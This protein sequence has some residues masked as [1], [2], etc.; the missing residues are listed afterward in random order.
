MAYYASPTTYQVST[1]TNS[2]A[3]GFVGIIAAVVSAAVAVVEFIKIIADKIKQKKEETNQQTF[4]GQPRY[5]M[6][7]DPTSGLWKSVAVYPQQQVPALYNGGNNMSTT[8]DVY[9]GNVDATYAGQYSNTLP[10]GYGYNPNA[11]DYVW[12]NSTLGQVPSATEYIPYSAR[13]GFD[14][15][16]W[17]KASTP[18]LNYADPYYPYANHPQGVNYG[19]NPPVPDDYLKNPNT[20]YKDLL[21]HFNRRNFN[22]FEPARPF[23]TYN[24]NSINAANT[25]V[26]PYGLSQDVINSMVNRSNYYTDYILNIGKDGMLSGPNNTGN[27]YDSLLGPSYIGSDGQ[28]HIQPMSKEPDYHLTREFLE[29][30]KQRNYPIIDGKSFGKSVYPTLDIASMNIPYIG[31]NTISSIGGNNDMNNSRR[32]SDPVAPPLGQVP[33]VN[34]LWYQQQNSQAN[35]YVDPYANMYSQQNQNNMQNPYNNPMLYNNPYSAALQ[36]YVDH[37]KILIDPRQPSMNINDNDPDARINRLLNM[38]PTGCTSNMMNSPY[39]Y[40]MMAQGMNPQQYQ[41]PQQQQMNYGY[42]TQQQAQSNATYGMG[43]GQSAQGGYSTSA[44][45]VPQGLSG[46][47]GYGGYN[48]PQNNGSVFVDE[49]PTMTPYISNG[50]GMTPQQ[51]VPPQ[52]NGYGMPQQQM[53]P[54]P[55]LNNVFGTTQQNNNG[56]VSVSHTASPNDGMTVDQ[57]FS[58]LHDDGNANQNN[59]QPAN[60]NG[61]TIKQPDTNNNTAVAE[62]LFNVTLKNIGD[63]NS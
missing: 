13:G 45:Y 27:P 26:N 18:Y 5:E 21:N 17:L 6:Q 2:G 56:N 38:G 49:A 9:G 42:N 15:V 7:Y 40:Q 10:Y 35:A 33:I 57:V 37:S 8:Y 46:Y 60:I 19:F 63:N 22:P 53:N 54:Q 4:V 31:Y 39:N 51:Q 52:S 36:P 24:T 61:L 1:T 47:G 20:G 30:N 34:Q 29:P 58:M 28:L 55:S 44:T 12:T 59:E 50:Y 48:Q 32:Y 14:T 62:G 23:A 3:G 16:G 11:Q 41:N 25:D 43:N